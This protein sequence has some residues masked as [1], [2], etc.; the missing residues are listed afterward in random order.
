M[1]S[2]N[3]GV[4]TAVEVNGPIANPAVSLWDP[5]SGGT[6]AAIWFVVAIIILFFVL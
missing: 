5:S 2:V 1:A 6:W 3:A 4:V